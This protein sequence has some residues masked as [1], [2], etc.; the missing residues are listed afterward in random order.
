LSHAM[1]KFESEEV[2]KNLNEA[3]NAF[4]PDERQE[5]VKKVNAVFEF[6]V[7]KNDQGKEKEIVQV[8]HADV[9]SKGQVKNGSAQAADVTIYLTD[10]DM[11]ALTTGDLS[12][13]RAFLSNRVQ[14]KG[15]MMLAMKLDVIFRSLGM[16][17]V[18]GSENDIGYD[19]FESSF[20][21]LQIVEYLNAL[22]E[23]ERK[24]EVA[25]VRGVFLLIVKSPKGNE[26]AIWMIDMKHGLGQVKKGRIEGVKP[27]LT[28][29]LKDKDFVDLFMGKTNAQKA[30][31]TGRVKAKGPVMLGVKLDNMMRETQD[32]IGFFSSRL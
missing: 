17:P 10:A 13:A 8:W 27:D 1:T 23:E 3:L 2:F 9:K 11:V 32:R 16:G 30:F 21:V 31:L 4:T 28:I 18:K 19:G 25:K 20:L 6:Q 22:T 24:A 14:L 5:L 15:P 29:E 12:G 7:R 26:K